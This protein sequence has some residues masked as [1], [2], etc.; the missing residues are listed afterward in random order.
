MSTQHLHYAA[1]VDHPISH[2][3]SIGRLSAGL[4]V[5]A[6]AA[7]VVATTTTGGVWVVAFAAVGAGSNGY[8]LGKMLGGLYDEYVA[9][10]VDTCFIRT[11]IESV[12][13]GPSAKQAARAG[14]ED[15][16]TR[17]D[18]TDMKMAEGSRIVMLGP[19]ARPMTRVGDRADVSCGGTVSDGL[20]SLIVGGAPSRE[21]ETIEE[22]D[23]TALW[24]A[25][26][27]ASIAGAVSTAGGGTKADLARAALQT[28]GALTDNPAVKALQPL[29][30]TKPKNALDAFG[31]GKTGWDALQSATSLFR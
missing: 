10:P 29:A 7:V 22:S 27:A 14:H 8:E 23:S 5:A 20:R 19:E 13:L 16:V 17:G 1:H 9:P 28:A 4:T 30:M 31:A 2:T 24:M 18:H 11:G 15:S 12:R 6:I 3:A 26:L 25:D 21:G